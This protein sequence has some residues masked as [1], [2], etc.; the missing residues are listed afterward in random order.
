MKQCVLPPEYLL[1]LDRS[2]AL[3][4]VAHNELEQ[5][6]LAGVHTRRLQRDGAVLSAH[7]VDAQ[8]QRAAGHNV[9]I[10]KYEQ[11]ILAAA[12]APHG[13]EQ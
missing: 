6:A 8:R 4:G 3:F 5:C 10:Q 11:V 2:L 12:R 7:F 1:R 13:A 9:A